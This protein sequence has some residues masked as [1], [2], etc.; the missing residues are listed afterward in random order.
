MSETKNYNDTVL[1]PFLQR[2]IQ[3]LTTQNL[4]LEANLVIERQKLADVQK[5][6]TDLQNQLI[7]SGF[8]EEE[9]TVNPDTPKKKR[10]AKAEPEILDANTY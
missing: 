7:E 2:K 10:K 8:A 6:L 9:P 1:I 5:E 3:E 4:I